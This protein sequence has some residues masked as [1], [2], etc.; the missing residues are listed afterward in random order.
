[1]NVAAFAVVVARERVSEHGDDLHGEPRLAGTPD[2]ADRD[3]TRRS[4]QVGEL[5]AFPLASNEPS[6]IGRQRVPEELGIDRHSTLIGSSDPRWP[7]GPTPMIAPECIV[8]R[9]PDVAKGQLQPG[10]LSTRAARDWGPW[11]PCVAVAMS[12]GR[13]LYLSSVRTQ[14]LIDST[15]IAGSEY[16]AAHLMRTDVLETWRVQ[17]HDSLAEDADLLNQID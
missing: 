1:M 10:P 13:W 8:A 5:G 15:L 16:L 11:K 3:H 4:E 17:S 14:G 9:S 12:G 6:E 2:T 7:P